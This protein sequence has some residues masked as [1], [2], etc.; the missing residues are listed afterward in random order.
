MEASQFCRNTRQISEDDCCTKE[1][2]R[3]L[4]AIFGNETEETGL[5]IFVFKN[6]MIFAF[7]TFVTNA[8]LWA[9]NAAKV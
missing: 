1:V 2:L 6:A 3:I 8:P 4:F 5:K 9:K 7:I